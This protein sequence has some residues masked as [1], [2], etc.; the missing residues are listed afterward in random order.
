MI[1][2]IGYN[3]GDS[4]VHRDFSDLEEVMDFI[5]IYLEI[6]NDD[7]ENLDMSFWRGKE[8]ERVKK[9]RVSKSEKEKELKE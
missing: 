7:F 5:K 4:R 9:S 3:R 1:I 8:E 6:Y 2:S